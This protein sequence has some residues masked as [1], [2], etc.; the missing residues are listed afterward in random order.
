M[1]KNIDAIYSADPRKV[2]DAKKFDEITYD[3]MLEMGLKV[4][5]LSATAFLRDNQ[6]K[7]YVFALHDPNN[8][9]DIV[10]GKNI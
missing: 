6:L 7:S 5:D 10:M 8:I 1:A 9:Y 4:I 2:P 3:K